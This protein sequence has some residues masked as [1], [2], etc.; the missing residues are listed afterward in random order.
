[1]MKKDGRYRFSLQFG[2]DSDEHIQIGEFLEQLGNKKSQIIV[3]AVSEYINNHP[4]T[5]SGNRKIE[6]RITSSYDKDK[7]EEIV[8]KVLEERLP[9]MQT[10]P[11]STSEEGS[12]YDTD[13]EN[14]IAQMLDNIGAFEN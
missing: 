14:D 12:K 4:E 3:A 9:A 8:R 7:I 2:T 1:M 10:A 11:I 13:I 6:V 5:Q